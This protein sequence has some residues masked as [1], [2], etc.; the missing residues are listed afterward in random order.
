VAEPLIGPKAT[1]WLSE[2]VNVAG[3][4]VGLPGI[5]S[6]SFFFSPLSVVMK[7]AEDKETGKL[8]LLPYS[9]MCVNG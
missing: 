2:C 8:P 6:Q 4:K 3:I 7:I 1:W 9:A 5:A